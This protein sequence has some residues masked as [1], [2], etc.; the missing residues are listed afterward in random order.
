M[1]A[2]HYAE[3]SPIEVTE[4]GASDVTIRWVINAEAGAENF[5]M[6]V[7]E[8]APGGYTPRHVHPWEHEVFILEGKGQVLGGEEWVD[9]GPGHV[10]FVPPNE[11]HQFQNTGTETVKLLCL[12][13]A[14]AGG[15]G[16][17]R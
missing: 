4:E 6:R 1:K 16:C 15:C 13:P 12:V 9:F 11:E 7:F 17:G 2:F 10:I 8:I 5:A 14:S 3:V